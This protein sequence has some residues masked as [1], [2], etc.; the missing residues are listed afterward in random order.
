MDDDLP[1]KVADELR[2]EIATCPSRMHNPGPWAYTG[3]LDKWEIVGDDRVCTF[4]GSLHPD[5]FIELC[6]EAI[7][8][9]SD[10]RVSTGKVGK[11]YIHRKSVQNA[12]FGGIKFY[13]YH[14]EDK[15]TE[16]RINSV[17]R[18]AIKASEVKLGELL[19]DLRGK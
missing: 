18:E 7:D 4:C 12:S 10:T 3:S 1:R 17:L 19:S 13:A 9:D 5:D 8:P 15:E 16:G 6:K 14:C 11:W 2:A